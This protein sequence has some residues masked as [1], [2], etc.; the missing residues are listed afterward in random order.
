MTAAIPSYP[1][2]DVKL[3]NLWNELEVGER[4]RDSKLDKWGP[5][6]DQLTSAGSSSEDVPAEYPDNHPFEYLSYMVP[7]IISENPRA[8]VRSRKQAAQTVIAQL[9]Q[10]LQEAVT[11]GMIEPD[12]ARSA[13]QAAKRNENT[14]LGIEHGLN[15]WIVQSDYI[16]TLIRIANDMLIG[17]GCAV[18][19]LGPMPGHPQRRWP[20]IE[21]ISPRRFV[22][23]PTALHGD[24]AK[25]CAHWSVEEKNEL[26][27]RPASGGWLI[28]K[29]KALAGES[30]EQ[31]DVDRKE[32][33]VY[34]M[35]VKEYTQSD[36]PGSD[37]GYNGGL[38]TIAAT[39][40]SNAE[41]KQHFIRKPRAFFG[42]PWGPYSL[43]GA[44]VEPDSPYPLSPLVATYNQSSELN[45][46]VRAMSEGAAAYKRI[47]LVSD[48]NPDLAAKIKETAHDFV[49]TVSDETFN[50][51]QV[52]VMEKGGVADQQLK[53][54][55]LF[56]DRLDR[57]SSLSDA[58]RGNVQQDITATADA[59]A[60]A[61]TSLR[62][63]HLVKQFAAGARR[64][65]ATNA[66]Y[67]YH[68]DRIEF[69][70]G[71]EAS[72]AMNMISPVFKGGQGDESQSYEDIE[73]EVE[74]N[75]MERTNESLL[76]R[77]V[78]EAVELIKG[79]AP[80]IVTMP[81]ID[82]RKMIRQ[83]GDALNLPSLVDVVD[84]QVVR[85]LA[86]VAQEQGMT[87][88][89]VMNTEQFTQG[90]QRPATNKARR[91]GA[92]QRSSKAA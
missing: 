78:L 80:M 48:K 56:R 37:E 27:K 59:I 91:I 71:E 90:A 17:F 23:D 75:S 52:V 53:H 9:E 77:Q 22:L 87:E 70:L 33:S 45:A 2:L 4:L 11:L 69:A 76:V 49:V 35:W 67:F 36:W 74:A 18:S 83:I 92:E 21:R 34:E 88:P 7:K 16:S 12:K 14:A 72:E 63:S 5:L 50:K 68:E 73:I 61:A 28:D 3:A 57:A 54:Y 43:F 81:H 32:I 66:W 42:P 58:A 89:Q 46:H 38:F 47:I 29:I 84:W 40:S 51:D 85:E 24:E 64:T 39:R 65:L 10:T 82:W 55:E 19:S 20:K 60:D 79:M 30:P 15:R 25:W 31:S 13:M 6:I 41:T 44:Y 26:L 62:T 1:V 8:R 86:Q